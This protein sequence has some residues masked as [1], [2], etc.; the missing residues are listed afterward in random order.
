MS[1]NKEHRPAHDPR[2]KSGEPGGV[3]RKEEV[4]QSGVWPESVGPERI[5]AD[6]EPRTEAEWGQAVGPG[7]EHKRRREERPTHKK[8]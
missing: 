4:G 7:P 6:A 3:G 5:P 8:R 2:R 1:D